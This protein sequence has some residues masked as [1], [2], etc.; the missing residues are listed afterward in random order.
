MVD[1]FGKFDL[2]FVE[3]HVFK[4]FV[5]FSAVSSHLFFWKDFWDFGKIPGMKILNGFENNNKMVVTKAGARK[6]FRWM[7]G[8]GV[9]NNSPTEKNRQAK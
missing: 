6:F 7:E 9:T 2:F 8:G 5:S 4:N 1:I 3:V